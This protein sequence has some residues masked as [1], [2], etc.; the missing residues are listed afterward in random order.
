MLHRISV[1]LYMHLLV[2][3]AGQVI[4][5]TLNIIQPNLT[6]SLMVNLSSSVQYGR[7][8]LVMDKNFCTDAAGNKFSRSQNS[9]FILHFDRR[10]AV[11][12]LRTHIPERLLQLGRETRTVQATNIHKNLELYLYFNKPVI[13]S[14]TE[15]S[16]SIH[17]T[18][19]SLLPISGDSLGNHRFGFKVNNIS[20]LAIVTVSLDSDLLASRYGSTVSPVAPITFLFDSQRPAVRLSTTSNMRTRH[21]SLPILIRFMKP[22]FGFNSSH[23]SVSGGYVQGFREASLSSYSVDIHIQED[24]GIVSISV[25]ENITKDVAGNRNLAS[26]IL[27]VKHY[28]LPAISLVLSS[29]ATATFIVTALSAGL[30]TISVASLQ[31]IGAFGRRSSSLTTDPTRNLFRIACHIQT[32]ALSRWLAVTLPVEYHEF[33]RGLQWSI[34]YFSLPWDIGHTQSVIVPSIWP[35]NPHSSSSKFVHLGTSQHV[36]PTSEHA[37]V[38][39]S[40]YGLPLSPAEYRSF[41]ESQ[42][43]PEAE[44][45][46]NANESDGWSDFKKSMFW[47]AV[48]GGSLLLLHV[49]LLLILKFRKTKTEKQKIYGALV[50]PRFE[51]FLIILAL[52]CVCEASAALLKGGSTA[53]T[54]VGSLLLAAVSF[55]VLALFLFLSAGITYGKLLQYKE[56]HK[57]GQKSH[58]YQELI[59]VTLG[60][61]KRGQ[62]TWINQS[63]SV[64]LTKFGPLFEDVRGPPKYMLSQ[65]V[66]ESSHIS[67][68]RIIASDDETEDAEAPFIQK[69][70]GILRIYYTLIETIKRVCL[71]I[72]A[73]SNSENWS[74]KAPTIILLCITSFQLFFMVLKKPFIKK[75]VQLVEIISVSSELGIF[76]ICFVLLE[77]TFSAKDEKNIGICMLALFLLA[78]LPQIMNEWY[79]LYRQTQQLDPAGKSLWKG[80]K[81]A[82]V[83]F[84]LYFIPQKLMKN[85]YNSLELDKFGDKVLADPSSSGDRNRSSGSRASSGNEKPWMKQLRELAKSSFSKDTSGTPN[86]PS[87]SGTRWS[88]LWGGTRGSRSSSLSTSGETKSKPKGLY[89]DLEAIFASK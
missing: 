56:V 72:L 31:S 2:Y 66:A 1:L 82:L 84:L 86:D 44:Y 21:K 63:N 62:W 85:A 33:A 59:R 47:L 83:G 14:A 29:F 49:L 39:T 77:K 16:N 53:G 74:S 30:L 75:K 51:I 65:F 76:A 45:V 7:V 55:A 67:G 57:E 34:P 87:T 4:P 81:A 22:V 10:T 79:A 5:S 89:K 58:W 69:L 48:L 46:S 26:N 73:G 13:N 42:N 35:T 68:D 54:I 9:W 64:Y 11:V 36:E 3:G 15:I 17:T 27:Q 88:G 78:F 12:N 37:D 41:F 70:F 20:S 60:P 71:G 80:L 61:G 6:Y 52:P 24:G 8:I 23:V 50:L 32:F 19:G 43:I 28:S 25:P 18:Q 38:A 40:L